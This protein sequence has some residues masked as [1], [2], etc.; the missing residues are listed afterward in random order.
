MLEQSRIENMCY[1]YEYICNY[2]YY[3][4]AFQPHIMNGLME[5]TLAFSTGMSPI[6]MPTWPVLN[7][8]LKMENGPP[9][10]V[11]VSEDIF[12]KPGKVCKLHSI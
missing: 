5:Q 8:T 9:W 1:T 11:T 2:S 6:L 12:A 7:F 4:T 10:T 3:N